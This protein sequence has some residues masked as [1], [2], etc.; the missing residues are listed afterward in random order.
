[1]MKPK[2]LNKLFKLIYDNFIYIIISSSQ[3]HNANIF[4]VFCLNNKEV[5]YLFYLYNNNMLLLSQSK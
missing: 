3:L 4:V 5:H 2:Y 1:M